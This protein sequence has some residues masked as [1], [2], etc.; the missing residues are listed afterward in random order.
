MTKST[1]PVQPKTASMPKG[2]PSATARRRKTIGKTADV[3]TQTNSTRPPAT[4]KTGSPRVGELGQVDAARMTKQEYVLTLL[5]QAEGA[6]IEEI[7]VTT[8][9]QQHSV[10]G[11]FAG[12]VKKKL[13]FNL[14]SSRDGVEARRYRIATNG[15]NGAGR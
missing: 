9:W 15:K 4:G 14:V 1:N 3:A 7:M 5:N 13:G 12:T 8:G 10:R 2:V 6:S 11:F